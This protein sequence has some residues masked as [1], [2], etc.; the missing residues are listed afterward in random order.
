MGAILLRSLY[1]WST[2]KAPRSKSSV[3][4][5]RKASRFDL[6]QR[7]SAIWF[8]FSTFA[9]MT[10][11]GECRN[12]LVSLLAMMMTRFGIEAEAV[13]GPVA[14]AAVAVDDV[15]EYFCSIQAAVAVALRPDGCVGML[16]TPKADNVSGAPS[17]SIVQ[18]IVEVRV[19][20]G[21]DEGSGAGD[22]LR[23]SSLRG[24]RSA[25]HSSEEFWATSRQHAGPVFVACD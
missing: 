3:L 21:R 5:C 4:D 22:R 23:P 9:A 18:H 25:V 12:R 20:T 10:A 16:G 7:I 8:Y 14:V 11:L 1:S 19:T 17:A 6:A 13:N 24:A 15:L 2:R